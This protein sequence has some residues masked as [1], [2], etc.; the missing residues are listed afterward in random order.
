MDSSGL[1]HIVRNFTDLTPDESEEVNALSRQFPY[2]QLFHLLKARAARDLGRTD[3]DAQLHEAGVY[4]TDRSILKWVITTPKKERIAIPVE[5]IPVERVAIAMETVAAQEPVTAVADKAIPITANSA[6]VL[7]PIALADD[8]LR[9][10][11]YHELEKLQKLK[12]DF[13][14]RVDEFNKIQSEPSQK[15]ISRGQKEPVTEA[16][17]EEIKTTKKKLKVENPKQKEQNEIIDQFI[18]TK[19]ALPK[20]QPPVSPAPDLSEDS[21]MFSDN[22]VSETLVDILLKQGKKEKAIEVLKK[23]IWKFPQKKAY[24]A[25]QIES[26]KN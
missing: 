12:H 19:P 7:E 22:I 21:G 26:L 5:D 9:N 17:L 14:A 18:K 10:D 11:I 25:A 13:E 8:A 15:K 3:K 4:A 24:F 16:L 1:L 6:H 2:S 23:L 20:A